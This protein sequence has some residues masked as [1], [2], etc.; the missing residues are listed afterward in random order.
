[1]SALPTDP[2][3]LTTRLAATSGL[4]F[5]GRLY[6]TEPPDPNGPT[7]A[8]EDPDGYTWST[9]AQ[10]LEQYEFALP[11]TVAAAMW[12]ALAL[13]PGLSQQTIEVAGR[14]VIA[15]GWSGRRVQTTSDRP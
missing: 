8:S 12:R 15:I 14:Q 7:N 1:L 9:I 2:K 3:A 4:L 13:V 11:P 5:T 10:A 6:S